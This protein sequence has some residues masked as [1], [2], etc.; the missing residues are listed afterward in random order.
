M[1]AHD[2][3]FASSRLAAAPPAR[4]PS[5]AAPR[6][7]LRPASLNFSSRPAQRT[8]PSAPATPLADSSLSQ[9]SWPAIPPPANKSSAITSFAFST[10]S[11]SPHA[12]SWSSIA[13]R[14]APHPRSKWSA[15]RHSAIHPAP[16]NPIP[17][18]RDGIHPENRRCRFEGS[19]PQRTR[20]RSALFV[21]PASRRLFL[22]AAVILS[23]AKDLSS[24]FPVLGATRNACAIAAGCPPFP[25]FASWEGWGS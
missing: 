2:T 25:A 5:A 12:S 10:S 22:R 24:F 13:S 3:A 17:P 15:E 23:A 21:A 1:T 19:A 20:E 6:K 4:T 16:V 7:F 11:A 8:I 18:P 9:S 14:I